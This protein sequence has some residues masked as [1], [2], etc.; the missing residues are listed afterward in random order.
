MKRLVFAMLM[1]SCILLTGC[2]LQ[3]DTPIKGDVAT[4]V[5][6]WMKGRW[7]ELKENVETQKVY[8]IKADPE[9]ASKLIITGLDPTG[10]PDNTNVHPAE[11]AT[12]N[13]QLFLSVYDAGDDEDDA[14]YYHYAVGRSST[15]D[16]QLVPMKEHLVS[17]GT[18][19]SELAAYIAAHT[20]SD[21]YLEKKDIQR[22]RRKKK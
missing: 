4:S 1:L 8:E 2:P 7:V 15:G 22:Y 18:S 11:V 16:L 10:K 9:N 3:T 5:P 6:G 13:T 21:D 14:G 12:V 19:G 17:S 20:N